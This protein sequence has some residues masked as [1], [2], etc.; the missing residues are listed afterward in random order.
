MA[1][2]YDVQR[3]IDFIRTLNPAVAD[4]AAA[5]VNATSAPNVGMAA[6][7]YDVSFDEEPVVSDDN[8][9]TRII[10]MAKEAAKAV[11]A[12]QQ[13]RTLLEINAERAKRGLPLLDTLAA[14][15]QVGLS[16]QVQNLIIIGGLFLAGIFVLN[17][18]LKRR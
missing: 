18:F 9:F 10:E 2:A 15:V 8:T 1:T 5:K 12:I 11:I 6:L 14:Q 17:T 16:P 7:P 3:Y 13:Q 4:M